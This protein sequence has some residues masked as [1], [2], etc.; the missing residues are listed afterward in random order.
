MKA[1]VIGRVTDGER[2]PGGWGYRSFITHT[3]LTYTPA[4]NR[5]YLKY[6]CLRF[7]IEVEPEVHTL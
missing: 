5:Q 7:Q 2:A 4:K 3:D 1:K 6:D